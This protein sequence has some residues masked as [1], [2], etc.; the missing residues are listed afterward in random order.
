[1]QSQGDTGE[2][3][4]YDMV[5]LIVLRE[6]SPDMRALVLQR[7]VAYMTATVIPYES[8]QNDP[9]LAVEYGDVAVKFYA[10]TSVT[11]MFSSVWSNAGY[12]TFEADP[13]RI[14]SGSLQR[15]SN[16][17]PVPYSTTREVSP[18]RTSGWIEPDGSADGSASREGIPYFREWR[19]RRL[20]RGAMR[21]GDA[22]S[23]DDADAHAMASIQ[24]R[25]GR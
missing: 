25:L 6:L 18:S 11:Y 23:G 16:S 13:Y 7:T 14:L 8:Q 17:D 15:L 2:D 21:A 4:W 1:M 20:S 3:G 5:A 22:G 19:R 12:G 24:A 9:V 10:S